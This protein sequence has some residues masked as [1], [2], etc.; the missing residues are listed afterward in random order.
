M[1]VTRI[2]SARQGFTLIELL[3]VIAIIAILA[4]ILFP[5]FAKARESARRA[6][7]ASNLKQIG[8]AVTQYTQE[9]DE[10][11]PASTMGY[12]IAGTGPFR[13]ATW[14]T[15]IQPY[16]KSSQVMVCPSDS[17]SNRITHPIYGANT[18]R[19]YTATWQVFGALDNNN[20]PLTL[21]AVPAPTMTVMITER[22]Q[23]FVGNWTAYSYTDFLRGGTGLGP[24]IVFRHLETTNMLYCDGHVK[25][26]RGPNV[27]FPGYTLAADG[28]AD[29]RYNAQLPQ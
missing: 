16:I 15:V 28:A 18:T 4:A 6:S 9:Y 11:Y 29:V 17:V 20:E 8:I 13:E 24:S 5:A 27:N 14:D 10:K 3:V 23:Q 7:C 19:S 26:Q 1:K 21:A 12:S 25:A 2:R 22:N